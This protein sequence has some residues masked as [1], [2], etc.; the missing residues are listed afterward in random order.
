M[1]PPPR[2]QNYPR[3]TIHANLPAVSDSLQSFRERN[4]DYKSVADRFFL[5]LHQGSNILNLPSRVRLSHTW[6]GDD[7][8]T[9][10]RLLHDESGKSIGWSEPFTVRSI[11]AMFTVHDADGLAAG[12]LFARSGHDSRSLLA[13]VGDDVISLLGNVFVWNYSQHEKLWQR[14][15]DLLHPE[16][17][18]LCALLYELSMPYVENLR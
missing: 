10:R 15:D 17:R 12:K 5:I 4:R 1:P 7:A 13:Q 9:F 8:A 2:L 14:S 16:Q 6:Q 3:I 18:S 11:C